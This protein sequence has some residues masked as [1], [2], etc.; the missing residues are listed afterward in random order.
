[1]TTAAVASGTGGDR[2][3]RL[4]PFDAYRIAQRLQADVLGVVCPERR[5]AAPAGALCSTGHRRGYHLG[6][7]SEALKR[8][9]GDDL[10]GHADGVD[11]EPAGPRG[12]GRSKKRVAA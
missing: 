2:G 11:D 3:G 9:F 4:R 5:C 12:R 10:G 7:F 6:R 1:M 8:E